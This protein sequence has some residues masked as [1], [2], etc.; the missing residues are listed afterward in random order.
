MKLSFKT[1][2]IANNF[3]FVSN[4]SEW[5]FSCRKDYN[6]AWL[7]KTGPLTKKESEALDNFK[8]IMQ[9]NGFTSKNIRNSQYI[10]KY[11]YFYPEKKSWNKLKRSVGIADFKKIKKVFN[12]FRPRFEKVWKQYKNDK[13]VGI[14]S[15][16]IKNGEHQKLYKDIELV[17]AGKKYT[18]K[19]DIIIIFSPHDHEATAA[20]SA[21]LGEKTIVLELP[22]L[23]QDT[24]QLEFSI[25][26]LAHE[27][28]HIL[29]DE[30]NGRN[31][32]EKSLKK[33]HIPKIIKHINFS[34]ILLINEAVIESF[35]PYGYLAQKHSDFRLAFLFLENLDKV[36]KTLHDFKKGA[37][38]NY[39]NQLNRY[40]LW[41]LYPLAVIY[42]RQKKKIDQFYVDQTVLILKNLIKK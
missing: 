13:R 37:A 30:R 10:G 29:F 27:I 32:I 38:V 11:F 41:Q 9:R 40:F 3:F 7:K 31:L 42:G 15:Q 26:I 5:H 33:F 23:K 2:K 18:K 21:C 17:F 34:P 39:Y 22:K 19:I 25:N 35:L 20:G 24:W 16:E 8:K 1:S 28:S 4:L 6:E 12:I 36:S 14:F